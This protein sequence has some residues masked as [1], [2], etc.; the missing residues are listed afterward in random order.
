MVRIRPEDSRVN[1]Q[2]CVDIS[3]A[4]AAKTFNSD[5]LALILTGMGSDGKDGARLLKQNNASVW[6]QNEE[7]CVVYGMPM[8]VVN[9]GLADKILGMDDFAVHLQREF[10]F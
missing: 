3:F 6:A 8:A 7:S 4:S 1:F 9:A 2:P 10:K 5:V